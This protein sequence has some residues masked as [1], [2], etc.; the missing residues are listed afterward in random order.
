MT[1]F[2]SDHD[3][4][5]AGLVKKQARKPARHARP[6]LPRAKDGEGDRIEQLIRIAAYGFSPRFDASTG[7]YTFWNPATGARTTAHAAYADACGA[8]EREVQ[9]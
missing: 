8:A 3:A 5:R 4:Q 6:D 7:L 2:I 1:I 9:G